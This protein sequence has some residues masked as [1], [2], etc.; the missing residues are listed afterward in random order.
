MSK[1]KQKLAE[2]VIIATLIIMI[3]IIALAVNEKIQIVNTGDSEYIIYVEDLEKTEY[4]YAISNNKEATGIE[5]TYINSEKDDLD[6]SV[7]LIDST[8]Y[9]TIKSGKAYLWVK[10]G[11]NQIISAEEIDFTNAFEKEKMA[12]VENTTKRIET[13]IISNLEEEDRVDENGV[14]ITVSVGGVKIKGDEKATYSYQTMLATEEYKTLMDIAEKINS[15]Y[16]NMTMYQKIQIA[17]EFSDLYNKL[18]NEANWIEVSDM[19]IRQPKEATEGAKYVVFIK[20]VDE[21]NEITLDAQFLTCKEQKTPKYEK[22]KIITQE[23]TKLPITNDSL[24]L[25]AIFAIIILAII[26]VFIRMKKLEKNKNGK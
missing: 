24:I 1:I 4:K 21:N 2:I 9:E 23:T 15:E 12:E 14:H 25:I 19:T 26:I 6:N 13:E 22:E 16:N 20:K 3:P 18:I 7:I 10:E 17:N 8:T 5:L 11:E